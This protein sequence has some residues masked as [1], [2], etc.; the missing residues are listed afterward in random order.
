[1]HRTLPTLPQVVDIMSARKFVVNYDTLTMVSIIFILITTSLRMRTG[2]RNV[3]Q[4]LCL[5]TGRVS[6]NQC[7]KLHLVIEANFQET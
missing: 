2:S 5:F 1:V 7:N 3:I 4:Q 6:T